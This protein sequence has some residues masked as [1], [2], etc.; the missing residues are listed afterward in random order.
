MKNA[1]DNMPSSEIVGNNA[2]PK[3]FADNSVTLVPGGWYACNACHD[4]FT[5]EFLIDSRRG[6]NSKDAYAGLKKSTKTENK[7][8]YLS[9]TVLRWVWGAVRFIALYF[10]SII[11]TNVLFSLAWAFG[12]GLFGISIWVGFYSEKSFSDF[13]FGFGFLGVVIGYF[14]SLSVLLTGSVG[15]VA[16]PRRPIWDDDDFRI[17]SVNGGIYGDEIMG[18]SVNIDGTPMIGDIDINGHV[19][20]ETDTFDHH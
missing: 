13:L 12:L 5:S 19:Y 11:A 8:R 6:L 16:K 15:L 20:G 17:N 7:R 4:N 9:K 10:L 3:C 14:H 1:V 2:C 18:P